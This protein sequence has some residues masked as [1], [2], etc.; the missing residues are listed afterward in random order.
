MK[1]FVLYL[2]LI[3]IAVSMI[4]PFFAMFLISLS[5]NE[6]IFIEYKNINLSLC[7][8]RNVFHSIPIVKYFL[9]SLIVA[10]CATIGQVIVSAFAGYGFAKLKFKGADFLFFIIVIIC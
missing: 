3:L 10:I 5:G 8:Y 4:L 7:S 2:F 9:N 1:K 6:N